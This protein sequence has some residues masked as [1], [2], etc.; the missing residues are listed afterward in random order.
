DRF[1]ELAVPT[2][3]VKQ[4]L[5]NSAVWSVQAAKDD[6]VWLGTRD[7]LNR[8]KDGKITT[9][10]TRSVRAPRTSNASTRR[11]VRS[12][13]QNERV[14]SFIQSAR[15]RIWTATL[16]GISY[17]ENDRFVPVDGVPGGLVNSIAEDTAGNLWIA[18]QDHGLLRLS[19]PPYDVQQIP[20]ARLG[21]D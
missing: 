16:A 9:Y 2:I 11:D 12:Q 7:G 20:W 10:R 21:R 13:K 6:G 19:P 1:R 18:N 14:Q 5:S 3:S 4:G 8:W 15:G 17:L